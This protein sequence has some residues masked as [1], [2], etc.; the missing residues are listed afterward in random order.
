M[1]RWSGARLV[2]LYSDGV[3]LWSDGLMVIH[4]KGPLRLQQAYLIITSVLA[5]SGWH[6]ADVMCPLCYSQAYVF[7]KYLPDWLLLFA[8]SIYSVLYVCCVVRAIEIMVWLFSLH[9]DIVAMLCPKGP[10][11]IL[12]ETSCER[13]VDIFPAL[14]YSCEYTLTHLSCLVSLIPFFLFLH[15]QLQCYSMIGW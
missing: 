10:L 11:R 9:S 14:I 7:V 5:V 1:R 2:D 6:W 8:I 13:N 15:A 4:W 3:E 12:V